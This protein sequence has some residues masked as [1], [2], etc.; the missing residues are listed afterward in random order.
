MAADLPGGASPHLP[1]WLELLR[2]HLHDVRLPCF[3][4]PFVLQVHGLSPSVLRDRVVMI[5]CKIEWGLG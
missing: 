5:D 2:P 4:S 1:Q 3:L